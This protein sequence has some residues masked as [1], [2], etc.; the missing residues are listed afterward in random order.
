[1]GVALRSIEEEV[2]HAGAGDVLMFWSHIGEEDTGGDL[3]AG[4]V[5]SGLAEVGF[6]EVGKAKEPEDGFGETGEDAKPGAEGGW[7]DLGG[8]G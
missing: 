1:M 4:P 2:A 3:G 7:F 8:P 5:E 6:A